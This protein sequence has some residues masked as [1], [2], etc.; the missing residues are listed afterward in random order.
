L[1][2]GQEDTV[3]L[4]G[5]YASLGL[6]VLTASVP[7][8][9]Q[10]PPA[11]SMQRPRKVEKPDQQRALEYWSDDKNRKA[12]EPV[13]MPSLNLPKQDLP[14]KAQAGGAP[15]R[16]MMRSARPK[17]QKRT[18]GPSVPADVRKP[19]YKW[20]GKLYFNHPDG[21]LHS[22]SAAYV[23]PNLI[24]TAAHCVVSRPAQ[25]DN[26][27]LVF[28]QAFK[29]TPQGHTGIKAPVVCFHAA[30][31][32]LPETDPVSQIQWDYAFAKVATP[33]KSGNLAFT[34][35]TPVGPL[36][37][38][39]G[40]PV[41]IDNGDR[42]RVA[43]NTIR[44][45]PSFIPNAVAMDIADPNFTRGAS[46]GPWVTGAVRAKQGSNRVVSVNSNF[47]PAFPGGVTM[48][49]PA[50]NAKTRKLREAVERCR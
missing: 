15:A 33:Q 12:A 2:V 22:C 46:G 7:A 49:G 38:A 5:L 18:A 41:A 48:Y 28:W 3:M 44:K 9:A 25:Q 24:M 37:R 16:K 21:S 20:A 35:S 27:N 1:I 47:D 14:P 29:E 19:P 10:E 8:L 34:A 40:Y 6:A 30:P 17:P 42:A 50:F 36:A 39:I 13:E 4:R 45:P 26:T 11:A 43:S 23:A 31:E 32:W